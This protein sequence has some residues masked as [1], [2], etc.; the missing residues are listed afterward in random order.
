MGFGGM[1]L[2]R[3]FF[4]RP[5]VE[6]APE[7]L[8]KFLVFLSP[9]GE[10]VSEISEVEAYDGANDPASH[11]FRGQTQRNSS[12]FLEGGHTYVYFTYG[13]H[14]CLNIVTGN[15]G[16]ACGAL[17]RSVI[18]VKGIEVMRDN[19]GHIQDPLLTN[20]PGKVCQAFGLH[21]NH[22]GLDLVTS[23]ELYLEDRGK[24]V[25]HFQQTPRIGIRTATDKLWRFVQESSNRN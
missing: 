25:N 13:M 22:N 11:A 12:M 7:L 21:K 14:H 18:P 19:R 24:K 2:P 6:V 20:G 5:V 4:V 1:R 16:V 10:L 3:S 9:Q 8:G 17:I 15:A 23:T